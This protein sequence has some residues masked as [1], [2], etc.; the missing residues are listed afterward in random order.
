MMIGSARINEF[1]ET[2]GGKPGDQTGWECAIEPWYLHKYGWVVLRA[3]S[4]TVRQMIALNMENICNNE[5]YGYDQPRD[6]DGINA[7]KPYGYDASK[8]KSPTSIDC[9]RAVQLCILYAG[10]K[11]GDFYTVTEADVIMKTGAFDKL[12]SPMYC[13][14][15]DY[16]MRGDILVTPVKG[17]TVVVL[18]DGPKVKYG[19]PYKVW[20]C[21]Y[22]NVRKGPSTSY[23][24]II[25]LQAGDVVDLLGW[26]S[27]GWGKIR[28]QDIIGYMSPLYLERFPEANITGKC[29]MRVK[30]GKDE[31]PILVMPKGTVCSLT[32]KKKTISKTPWYECIY[33]EA[34][35]WSSGTYVKPK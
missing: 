24:K 33:K 29:W 20:N 3:K 6:H 25:G 4:G 32:G 5:N 10:I 34:E 16:L 15:S 13:T 22:A 11:V 18:S 17:H 26:A 8:V 28:Y 1:G 19:E 2:S 14:S 9:A 23:A 7:A 35:G 12:T 30:A 31:K 27:N 21:A